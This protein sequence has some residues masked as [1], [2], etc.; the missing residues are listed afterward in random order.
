MF[1]EVTQLTEEV[2][3]EVNIMLI[4]DYSSTNKN[5]ACSI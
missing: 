1:P 3:N 5:V 4:G 2:L